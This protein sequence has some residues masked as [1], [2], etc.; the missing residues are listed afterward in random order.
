MTTT[1]WLRAE[2]KPQE[3][4]SAI[5]PEHARLLLDNGF[6]VM[7]EKSPQRAI[8]DES[9]AAAGCTMVETGSWVNAPEDI[10][11]LG[12]KDLPN[13]DDPLLHQHIYFGH[14]Y[15]EQEG[16]RSLLHRFTAG[17]GKLYDIEYLVDASNRRVAAFGYWAGFTGCAVG[18]KVWTGQQLE[19]DPVVP[20]IQ[21]YSGQV[22]LVTELK[23]ELANAIEASGRR[24][25]LIIVGAAG[26]VGTG[27]SDLAQRLGL[28]ATLWDI[29]ETARGGPFDEILAHDLFVNCVL[30]KHRIAPFVTMETL[31]GER[32]LSVISDVSCDPGEYNPVPVYT[33]ATTFSQPTV[34]VIS[35]PPLDVTA[36]DH[37]PSM[38][39]VE[40]TRDFG[41]QLLPHLLELGT[42]RTGVW[43]RAREVFD[44]KTR[45]LESK[46][47]S[48]S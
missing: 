46:K 17:G 33:E 44:E 47:D 2:T 11:V 43:Q 32:Q 23:I 30:V 9:Y 12:V 19:L 26:R 14:A 38:L 13:K 37:L 1:L 16:W 6:E 48:H 28:E 10:F 22:A 4:R 20:P 25:S 34:R 35:S 21:P 7:V 39:P 3:A 45:E 24:P 31:S 40:A 41:D 8:P 42:D 27:A 29:E 15:K 36:I 5:A 18:V